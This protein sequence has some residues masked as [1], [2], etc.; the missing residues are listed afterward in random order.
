MLQHGIFN[1]RRNPHP[2]ARPVLLKC[3]SST[4]HRS[5]VSLLARARS[6]FYAPPVSVG[7]RV[8]SPGAACGSETPTG[9]ADAGI[10]VDRVAHGASFAIKPTWFFHPIDLLTSPLTGLAPKHP[11]QI[12]DLIGI[13]LRRPSAP[14]SLLQTCQT[15]FFNSIRPI[16]D[17]SR[18]IS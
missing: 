13:Q 18:S 8:R 1:F 12:G 10:V 17:C 9:V 16:S 11:S 15:L 7:R 2:T 4:A 14:R 5:I 6:F 3:T